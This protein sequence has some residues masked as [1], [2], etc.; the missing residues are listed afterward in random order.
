MSVVI[1]MYIFAVVHTA[2]SLV[3]K[4]TTFILVPVQTVVNYYFFVAPVA[5]NT[6]VKH[7]VVVL[8]KFLMYMS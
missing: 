6:A 2:S 3:L 7:S 5:S 1:E 4:F 8:T